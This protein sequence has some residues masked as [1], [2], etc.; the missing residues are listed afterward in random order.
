[1]FYPISY[2]KICP[3]TSTPQLYPSITAGSTQS[4]TVVTLMQLFRSLAPLVQSSV[5]AVSAPITFLIPIAIR[6]QPLDIP[7][8]DE[9]LFLFQVFFKWNRSKYPREGRRNNNIW[10]PRTSSEFYH[11]CNNVRLIYL[12]VV[13]SGLLVCFNLPGKYSGRVGSGGEPTPR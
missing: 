5:H 7:L 8:F 11:G 2:K 9:F 10:M 1:M 12:Y 3:W 4:P 6:T 13:L